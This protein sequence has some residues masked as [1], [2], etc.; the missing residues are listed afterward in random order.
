VSVSSVVWQAVRRRRIGLLWWVIGVA[1]LTALVAV[2]YPTVRDNRE[3]GSTFADLPPGVQALLGLDGGVITSPV[4]YLNSQLLANL[5]PAMLL[6]FAVGMAAWSVAGDERDGTLELLLANPISRTRVALARLLAMALLLALLASVAGGV[7]VALAPS[8]GLGAT[9]PAGR[10]ISAAGA[11]ALM[12]LTF[13]AVAFA[14][15]AITGSRG[16]AIAAAAALAFGGYL[17]EGL[18]EA[19]P[20]LRWLRPVNPWHWL[21]NGN[22]LQNGLTPDIWL[23]P[24]IATLVFTTASLLVFARRDLR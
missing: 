13:A 22:P 19:A 9:L 5:L 7:L 3:L 10:I 21:L 17:V 8:T 11:C 12:G 1:A 18:A 24:A 14:V 16:A 2:A 4:G 15:G 23:G 20:A 6:I